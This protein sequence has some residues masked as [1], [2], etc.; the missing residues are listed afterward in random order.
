MPSLARTRCSERGTTAVS[1]D[2]GDRRRR[3]ATMT[4]RSPCQLRARGRPTMTTGGAGR[5]F[6]HR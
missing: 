6:V 4:R 3:L 2:G 1:C 5:W